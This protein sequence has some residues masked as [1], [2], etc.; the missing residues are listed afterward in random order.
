AAALRW[1]REA[2]GSATSVEM[3]TTSVTGQQVF[4]DVAS[5]IEDTL[6]SPPDALP[7]YRRCADAGCR[8]G[9]EKLTEIYRS[10]S[11]GVRSDPAAASRWRQAAQSAKPDG[12]LNK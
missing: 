10:G 6:R 8:A 3:E 2:A 9:M 4:C 12:C 7:W 11:H 1:Y 5:R